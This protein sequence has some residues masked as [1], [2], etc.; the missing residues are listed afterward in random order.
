MMHVQPEMAARLV[1]WR[2][3]TQPQ[4]L[5]EVTIP[6][7]TY[8]ALHRKVGF[9]TGALE[10]ILNTWDIADELRIVIREC[11]ERLEDPE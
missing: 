4:P 7:A 11:L 2:A 10:A 8:S 5:P 6:L 3:S 1:A 9:A